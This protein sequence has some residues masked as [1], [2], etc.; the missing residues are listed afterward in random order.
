MDV[1]KLRE[2]VERVGEELRMLNLK[3]QRINW[4]MEIP[5]PRH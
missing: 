2:R 3:I 1:V 5:D 4:E